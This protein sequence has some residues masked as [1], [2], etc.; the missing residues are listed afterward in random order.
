MH[1]YQRPATSHDREHYSPVLLFLKINLFSNRN[2]L[3]LNHFL[4]EVISPLIFI[5]WSRHLTAAQNIFREIYL[6]TQKK[7]SDVYT[8][9]T[10][11]LLAQAVSTTPSSTGVCPGCF[12]TDP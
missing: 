2:I 6:Q 4:L 1:C 8:A 3:Q 10:T 5:F 7:K 11:H 9:E 12:R